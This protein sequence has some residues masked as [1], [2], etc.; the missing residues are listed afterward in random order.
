MKTF[1]SLLLFVA[2]SLF[3]TACANTYTVR[4]EVRGRVTNESGEPIKGIR[5]TL[6]D[7]DRESYTDDSGDYRISGV[8]LTIYKSQT[9]VFDDV[10]GLD[11]GG[12]FAS[13]S[14]S[15]EPYDEDFKAKTDIRIDVQMNRIN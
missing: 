2:V 12:E 3:V 8:V 4:F 6:E 5:V 1:K 13:T 11:N 9:I 10:D 15:F 14:K 7:F